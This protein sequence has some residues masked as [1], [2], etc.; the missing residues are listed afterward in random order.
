MTKPTIH[1]N[2]TSREELLEQILKASHAIHLAIRDLQAACP[3]GRDYYPQGPAV[4]NQAIDEHAARCE[5]LESVRRE[6]EEIAEQIA[7]S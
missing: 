5:K 2:G 1:R 6:L 3:N 4:I 7:D